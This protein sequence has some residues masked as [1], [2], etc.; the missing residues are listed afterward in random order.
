MAPKQDLPCIESGGG[1]G[2]CD[3]GEVPDSTASIRKRTR[4]SYKSDTFGLAR[5][6]DYSSFAITF[7]CFKSSCAP[8]AENRTRCV[9][10]DAF[11]LIP[12]QHQIARSGGH[13]RFGDKSGI[14]GVCSEVCSLQSGTLPRCT[15]IGEGRVQGDA[16]W[17]ATPAHTGQNRGS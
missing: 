3:Y 11:A 6:L 8:Q 13:E 9:Q 16:S 10:R 4:T 7:S 15:Q 5:K 1:S 2:K 14:H 17:G 12:G